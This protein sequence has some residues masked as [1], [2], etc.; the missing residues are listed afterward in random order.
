MFLL[1]ISLRGERLSI[2]MGDVMQEV[3]LL[4]CVG[5]CTDTLF[6]PTVN[7]LDISC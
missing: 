5:I 4:L 7:T 3:I 1:R 6:R 2:I